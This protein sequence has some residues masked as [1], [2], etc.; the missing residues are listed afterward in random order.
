M[1]VMILNVNRSSL[2][3]HVVLTLFFTDGENGY[4]V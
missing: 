3:S 4:A 2:A 1:I